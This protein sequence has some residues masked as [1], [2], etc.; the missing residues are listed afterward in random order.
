MNVSGTS[1]DPLW[2]QLV[3]ACVTRGRAIRGTHELTGCHAV[4]RQPAHNVLLNP[5][6]KLKL[7][8]G[9]AELAWYLSGQ[10]QIWPLLPFAPSYAKFSDDGK[11]AYGAYG[12]RGLG[13]L[14][15]ADLVDD[16]KANPLSRQHV[17]PIWRA[18]DRRKKSKDIPCTTALHF[19]VTSDG[20]EL[21]VH[22]RS[23]DL[24]LG[25]PYDV[26]CFTEIQKVVARHI[27]MPASDYHHYVSSLHLY[28]RNYKQARNANAVLPTK[29]MKLPELDDASIRQLIIYVNHNKVMEHMTP[30]FE[31]VYPYMKDL[32]RDSH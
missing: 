20:L 9:A 26:F 16:L 15:L 8:Y 3:D 29:S 5:V 25:F 31:V 14:S 10:D 23:N 6:R 1:I 19:L 30:F 13:I 28:D 4:L 18:A 24:W 17:I 7:G 32:R 2:T 21:H 12:P 11:T 27:G 22:M